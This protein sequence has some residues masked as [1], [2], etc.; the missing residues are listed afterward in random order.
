MVMGKLQGAPGD[1]GAAGAM[2]KAE[3]ISLLVD[4][5]LDVE[6]IEGVCTRLRD[7]DSVTTWVCY[8]VIGDA[9][10]GSS[11]IMPGFAARFATRLAAEPTVLSPPRR[12]PA[13]AAIAWAAAATVAAVSVVA[14]VAMTTLPI[15]DA[16]LP[17][18]LATAR[19]AASVRAADTR[20]AVD[21]EYLLVHQEYSPT[22][23]IQGARPYLRAVAATDPNARP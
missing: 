12:G 11:A 5:E 2:V 4:G 20:P 18:A 22:T 1:D 14:W 10:R 17:A 21:N 7:A 15:G 3:E 8:H 16:S 6:R 13:P 9:L 23:A 19:Q